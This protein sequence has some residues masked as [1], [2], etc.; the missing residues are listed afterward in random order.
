ML[1]SNPPRPPLLKRTPYPFYSV[2]CKDSLGAEN[3][4]CY[5]FGD[6]V[7]GCK[8]FD[9]QRGGGV[10]EKKKKEQPFPFLIRSS[11]I[12]ALQLFNCH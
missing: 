1:L 3:L 12:H 6:T 5:V 7:V 10:E 4:K 11:V 9:V 8:G 2:I